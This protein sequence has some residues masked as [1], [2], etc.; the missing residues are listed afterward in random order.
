VCNPGGCRP[1]ISHC[2]TK[3][4]ID[5]SG[6]NTAAIE[7]HNAKTE[8]GIKIRQIKYLNNIVEQDHRAI[9]RLARL[10]QRIAAIRK[11]QLY[12]VLS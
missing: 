7:S 1:P 10:I 9:K 8:A 12:N 4:T 11:R 6:A 3:I 5:K 2:I